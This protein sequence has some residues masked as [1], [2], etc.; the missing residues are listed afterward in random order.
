MIAA[1]KRSVLIWP[2]MLLI[3]AL[4]LVPSFDVIRSS[5]FDPD[6][7]TRHIDRLI[8][9]PVF[10]TVFW[11]T[12]QTSLI[13]AFAGAL[14]AWPVAYFINA[15][16]RRSQFLLIFL[17]FIPLWMSVLIRSY[18]WLVVLGRDG[19]VNSAMLGMGLTTEPVQMLFTPAA[20]QLAMLQILLPIQI[21]TTYGAMTEI[22]LDLMRAARILGARQGQALRRVFIPLSFDG[23]MT[24]MIIAF[25]LS[26]GFFITPAL[27]G[28]PRDRMLGNL[29]EVQVAQLNW[30]FASALGLLLLFG[31]LGCVIVLRFCGRMAL[32]VLK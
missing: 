24:G 15:Q 10:M 25:M 27:L 16:P 19:V 32:R 12:V 28:G 2:A 3:V 30:G 18:A 21:V 26:M 4:Y 6:L 23:A 17:I 7:T 1:L 11:R 9:R 29:I 14:I 5:L 22:D 8:D 13:V 20:V 31:T